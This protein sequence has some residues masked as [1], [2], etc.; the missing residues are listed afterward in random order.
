MAQPERSE[1]DLGMN[2]SDPNG[3]NRDDRAAPAA[4]SAPPPT[5]SASGA[6]A[7]A[8]PG[9]DAMDRLGRYAILR[10]L[11]RSNDIVYEGVDS[12]IGRRVA[13]KELNLPPSLSDSAREQRIT[14]F[15]REARAAGA[16]NHPNIVTIHEVGEEHG[17][18]FIAMEFLDGQTLRKRLAVKGALPE[19]EAAQICVGLLEALEYAHERGVVHRDIKPD[20]V[21]V[22]EGTGGAGVGQLRIKL[23]DFGIARIAHEETITATGQF[24][25]TPSYMSPEQLSGRGSVDARSDLF[26]LGVM[27]WEMVMGR[28]PFTGDSVP[29]TMFRILNDPTPAL[30]EGASP[31][32]DTVV[33]KAT[34]KNPAQRYQ[35][36]AEMRV[37]LLPLATGRPG[38]IEAFAGGGGVA[39]ASPAIA[40]PMEDAFVLA[41]E[42]VN[43]DTIPAPVRARLLSGLEAVAKA[44]N[45]AKKLLGQGKLICRR[46]PGG[47]ILAFFTTDALAPVRCAVELDRSFRETS[48]E[49]TKQT[50]MQMRV[51]MGIG[52]GPVQRNDDPTAEVT[53]DA[54]GMTR[55]VLRLAGT[56][57][58]PAEAANGGI[59]ITAAV[60]APALK[61]D[62]W[63]RHLTDLA[64]RD[65]GDGMR[66]HLYNLCG[67]DFGSATALPALGDLGKG[68]AGPDIAYRYRAP[69]SSGAKVALVLLPLLAV[70]GWFGYKDRGP[71]KALAARLVAAVASPTNAGASGAT[72]GGDATKPSDAT[73]GAVKKHAKVAHP[74]RNGGAVEGASLVGSAGQ[75]SVGAQKVRVPSLIGK[76]E[77]V[78]DQLLSDAGL[79]EAD[80]HTEYSTTVPADQVFHQNPAAGRMVPAGT[81][82]RLAVSEGPDPSKDGGNQPGDTVTPTPASDDGGPAGDSGQ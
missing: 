50:G 68:S 41:V 53:G 12:L 72:G 32:L 8:K 58:G 56:G 75:F 62:A 51:R 59:L 71:I 25:G 80:A 5:R 55:R 64:F 4:S 66:I 40:A 60:A 9:A 48:K 23:T 70:G 30:M 29:H 11:A 49:I 61:A 57:A 16:M 46:A 45:E 17:R 79:A 10:E 2:A 78:A 63:A 15:Y 44:T 21:F 1:K 22:N 74:H 19:R 54:V 13:V 43:V 73:D 52:S 26:S 6:P 20:N 3:L 31:V 37:A 36:A 81:A 14:R 47:L 39:S 33:R 76:T 42:V 18:Y 67:A 35:N 28:K 82:V 65:A 34:A 69:M 77:S 7:A 38:T 24:F 27:L